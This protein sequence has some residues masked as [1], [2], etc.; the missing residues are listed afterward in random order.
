MD[1]NGKK[2]AGS[3]DETNLKGTFIS[4]GILGFIIV[5]SWFAIFAL[6]ISR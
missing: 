2:H 1:G 4:V 3:D 6:F 5:V